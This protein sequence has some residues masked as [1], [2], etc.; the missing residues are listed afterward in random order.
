MNLNNNPT[1]HQLQALLQACDD[2]AGHHILWVDHFGEV[3]ITLLD[4][5]ESPA[6]WSARMAKKVRFRFHSYAMSNSYVGESAAGDEDYVSSL[7]E[8][9]VAGWR[10]GA[11]GVIE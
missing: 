2:T 9:L 1:K 6:Q 3:Q 10:D 7:F 5:D 8:Q 4:D 11:P